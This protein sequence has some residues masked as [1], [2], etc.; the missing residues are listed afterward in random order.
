[1][2]LARDV[3]DDSKVVIKKENDISIRRRGLIEDYTLGENEPFSRVYL[4]EIGTI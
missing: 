3:F 4:K 2:M 1:M